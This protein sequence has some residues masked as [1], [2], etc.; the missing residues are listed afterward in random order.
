MMIIPE[1]INTRTLHKKNL[2]LARNLNK[3]KLF[4][5]QNLNQIKIIIINLEIITKTMITAIPIRSIL[6]T[7]IMMM[8]EGTTT[9]KFHQI[10]K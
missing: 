6:M 8:I 9:I 7:M 5:N 4:I 3:M 10:K 1:I 2:F